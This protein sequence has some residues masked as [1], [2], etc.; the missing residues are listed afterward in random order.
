V[1]AEPIVRKEVTACTRGET[2][3]KRATA[4]LAV[5]LAQVRERW[6]YIDS[7]AELHALI[8]VLGA[9]RPERLVAP[10]VLEVAL[11]DLEALSECW[12]SY[13]EPLVEWLNAR[14]RGSRSI[15]RHPLPN[16]WVRGPIDALWHALIVR[17]VDVIDSR[18][19]PRMLPLTCVL[20]AILGAP[21]TLAHR[22]H[23]HAQETS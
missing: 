13:D 9:C 20:T 23:H 5:F 1:H 6:S 4:K 22:A 15:T 10:G 3:R 21:N 11:E 17:G 18:S 16:P 2:D 12:G 14:T 7:T 8:E 19:T